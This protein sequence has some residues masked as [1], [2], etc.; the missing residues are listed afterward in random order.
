MV[1]SQCF[2][3]QNICFSYSLS[4]HQCALDSYW[5][6]LNPIFE[7]YL[8]RNKF[9]DIH[10][11]DTSKNQDPGPPGH[12]PLAK[13]C[14]L[15]ATCQENFSLRCTYGQY[16]SVDESTLAFKNIVKFL[17]CIH[18]CL[19]S[20]TRSYSRC[21]N[22]ELDFGAKLENCKRIPPPP[23][24]EIV[25]MWVLDSG[26]KV[27]LFVLFLGMWGWENHPCQCEV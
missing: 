15:F 7:S 19:I 10:I 17:K 11:C 5:S 24:L 13:V 3:H 8:R 1:R 14:P 25:K 2:W 4:Y 9:Q 21:L 12:D 18:P 23:P 20:F 26:T 6:F 22:T 27:L 16:I